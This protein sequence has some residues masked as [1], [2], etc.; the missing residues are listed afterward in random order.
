ML[1]LQLRQLAVITNPDAVVRIL[2]H[3]G[4][5]G[6]PLIPL[7]ARDPPDTSTKAPAPDSSQSQDKHQP[8]D[9]CL[10]AIPKDEWYFI[11]STFND[12]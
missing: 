11:D 3:L 12:E 6:A 4:Q 1:I 5:R 2:K 8:F 10:D 7:P 9:P